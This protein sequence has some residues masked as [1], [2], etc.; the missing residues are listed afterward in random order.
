MVYG[1]RSYLLYE[2]VCTSV[3]VVRSSRPIIVVLYVQACLVCRNSYAAGS[4]Y[5]CTYHFNIEHSHDTT[6]L[7]C[8]TSS[9]YSSRAQLSA[10]STGRF[11]Y[12]HYRSSQ[13]AN[14]YTF[15]SL[16]KTNQPAAARHPRSAQYQRQ[17]RILAP[18]HSPTPVDDYQRICGC[19]RY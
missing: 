2:L 1:A 14:P 5:A 11:S 13:L 10:C 4:S 12:T 8:R 3:Q 18:L 9:H 7:A 15:G 17:Q 6:K 19:V 16:R